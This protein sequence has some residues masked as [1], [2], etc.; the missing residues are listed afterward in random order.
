VS[1]LARILG[2]SQPAVSQHLRTLKNGKI[3]ESRKKGYHVYFS[4]NRE[5]M[6]AFKENFDFLYGCVMNRCDQENSNSDRSKP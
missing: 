4:F 3:I 1:N 5:K 2:I 6:Q